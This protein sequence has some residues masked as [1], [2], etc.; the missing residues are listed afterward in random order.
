MDS[1]TALCVVVYKLYTINKM[2]HVSSNKNAQI[3]LS[4]DTMLSKSLLALVNFHLFLFIS[5]ERK[6]WINVRC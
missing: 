1:Q 4:L 2:V 5:E 6:D 3:Q